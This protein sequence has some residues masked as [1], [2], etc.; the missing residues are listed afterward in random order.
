MKIF[1][2]KG[3]QEYAQK[4]SSF[5]NMKLTPHE[6]KVF[7]DGEAYLKPCDGEVGNVRG[8]DVVIIQSLYEDEKESINDKIMKLCVMVGALKDGSA[9]RIIVVAPYKAYARQDRKTASRAPVTTKT[10]YRMLAGV[11]VNH[12]LFIDVHNLAAEQNAFQDITVDVLESRLLI[13][14]WCVNNLSNYDNIVVLSPDAGGYSRADRFRNTLIKVLK[15]KGKP[16]NVEI[17]IFDKLR[18]QNEIE[19]GKIVGDVEDSL[20]ICFDDMISTGSTMYKAEQAVIKYGGQMFALIATHGL[21]VGKANEYLEKSKA[22]HFVVTDT[23]NPFRLNETNRR[24]L[25]VISTA[26]MVA[27]A[28]DRIHS[29]TGSISDLLK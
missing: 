12:C 26:E 4:V 1:G 23:V 25:T 11:G 14:N 15:E 16:T 18:R 29:E 13:A 10:L 5:L 6:E 20:V 22:N 27:K 7:E 24:R 19:G 28:I 2:L 17:A 21:F 8:H 9:A 3:S